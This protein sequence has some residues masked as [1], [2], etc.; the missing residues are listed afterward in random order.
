[1]AHYAFLSDDGTVVEVIVGR[2][3][4]DGGV[5]WEQHYAEVR[6]MP[7]KRTSYNTRDGVHLNGGVPYRGTYAGIGYRY[8]PVADVF[9]PPDPQPET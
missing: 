5:D 6:G 8:D 9:V 4:G 3:E 1:M 7:C 2:D